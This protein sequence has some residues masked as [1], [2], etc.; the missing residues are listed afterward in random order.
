VQ[1]TALRCSGRCGG[2]VIVHVGCAARSALKCRRQRR[3]RPGTTTVRTCVVDE[4][5]DAMRLPR[6]TSG[7]EASS[8]PAIS[9]ITS[10]T[11]AS[12]TGRSYTVGDFTI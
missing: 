10:A 8:A 11:S 12:L 5:T 9:D 7:H 4:A 1:V 2:I 6:A 3:E